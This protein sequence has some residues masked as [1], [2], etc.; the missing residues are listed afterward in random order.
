MQL[1][2]DDGYIGNSNRYVLCIT[3]QGNTKY[4]YITEI[5]KLNPHDA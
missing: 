5:V 3:V 1:I 4:R 2:E